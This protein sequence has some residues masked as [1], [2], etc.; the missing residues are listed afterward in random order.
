MPLYTFE[1]KTIVAVSSTNFSAEGIRE[2]ADIQAA[3]RDK[4]DAISPN[5]LILSEEFSEWSE[6]ARRIDLL[7]IDR[8]AKLVVIELKRDETGAHMELQALRYAAM[9][10]TMTFNRTIEIHQKYLNM[11]E[12]VKDAETNIKEFLGWNNTEEE[13]FLTDVRIVLASANFSKELTTTVMWLNDRK[14]DI[15]CV[16]LQPYKMG[17]K[18]LLDI[19]QIIPLPEAEDYQVRVREQNEE[20]RAVARAARDMTRYSFMGQSYRKNRL[21]LA[22][23]SQ[24]LLNHP[25][26][27][28]QQLKEAFPDTLQSPLGVTRTLEVANDRLQRDKTPRYFLL[29]NEVLNL[30]DGSKIVVCNQWGIGNIENFV[31]HARRKH[32]Y[33]IQD[34][35]NM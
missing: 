18:V 21:V 9:I 31:D 14:I 26:T 13:P 25:D 30:T 8:D 32:E 1:D 10:S 35:T 11:R 34:L 22:I 16:R 20:R 12:I 28:F 19:E 24:Y 27:D 33:E 6:G 15:R 4:I 17:D 23:I 2:R 3:L 5:T 29:D 7:G